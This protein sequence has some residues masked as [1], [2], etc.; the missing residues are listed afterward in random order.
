MMGMCECE[1]GGQNAERLLCQGI[2]MGHMAAMSPPHLG[3]PSY[4]AAAP[5]LATCNTPCAMAAC[6]R[7]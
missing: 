7:A 3:L 6:C 5:M 2:I 1:A 4:K